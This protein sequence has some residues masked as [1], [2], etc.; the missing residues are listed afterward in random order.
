[1]WLVKAALGNRYAVSVLALAIVV[2]GLVAAWMIPVDILPIFRSPAVQTLTFYTG[3][4]SGVVEMNITNGT[5]RAVGQADGT[6]LQESKSM[7][8]VS[9]VRNYFRD[10]VNPNTALTQVNSLALANLR[11]LPPGTLPPIV[12]PFDP[13]ATMPI[14]MLSVSSDK[15]GERELQ[16]IGRYQL[17]NAVQSVNGAVAPAVFGGK[18]RAVLAYV[19]RDKLEARGLSPVDVV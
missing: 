18:S 9:I 17:R 12:L 14:C 15:L 13:T 19:D 1:M 5:E 3:M 2:V 10:D 7:V 11:Y 16:D 6:S 4:P 8:G